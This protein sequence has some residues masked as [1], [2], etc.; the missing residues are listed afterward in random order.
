MYTL[1]MFFNLSLALQLPF[2]SLMWVQLEILC[3][4]CVEILKLPDIKLGDV[5][6]PNSNTSLSASTLSLKR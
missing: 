1:Q 5:D 4:E 2:A 6:V 3:T